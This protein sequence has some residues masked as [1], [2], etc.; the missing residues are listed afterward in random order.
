MKQV[1]HRG[2]IFVDNPATG[3]RTE[4]ERAEPMTAKQTLGAI[5]APNGN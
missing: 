5:I 1:A 2:K 4:V 3:L